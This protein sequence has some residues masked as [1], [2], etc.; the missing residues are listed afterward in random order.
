MFLLG[1]FLLYIVLSLKCCFITCMKGI[2][3]LCAL[4]SALVG[5]DII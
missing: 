2:W 5:L 1:T 4:A 3:N